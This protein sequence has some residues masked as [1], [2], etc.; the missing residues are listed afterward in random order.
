VAANPHTPLDVLNQ[1]LS[2]DDSD[3]WVR[4]AH[5]PAV[6][7]NQRRILIDLLIEK[8]QQDR[9]ASVLPD[10]FFFQHQDLPEASLNKMLRS[11]FWRDRYL[12]VQH[13]R[14]PQEMLMALAH[15]GNR[16][17]RAA[18]RTVLIKQALYTKRVRTKRHT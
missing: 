14:A 9:T 5:H 7:A 12:V 8:V 17:V 18:A 13:P 4:I 1:L 11:A 10:W 6:I 3:L 15:D 16:F 2:T